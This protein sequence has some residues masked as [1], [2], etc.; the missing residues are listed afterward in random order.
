MTRT[1]LSLLVLTLSAVSAVSATSSADTKTY[2]AAFC[3][4]SN[5]VESDFSRS[6]YRI[7]KTAGS[8]TGTLLCPI[9]HDVFGCSGFGGCVVGI[10]VDIQVL[11]N[12]NTGDVVCTLSARKATGGSF[13]YSTDRTHNRPGVN[14]T[15]EVGGGGAWGTSDNYVLKCS[16]PK[17]DSN[18]YARY[19]YSVDEFD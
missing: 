8:S 12:H 2:H 15:L 4:S 7:T 10:S 9:V 3:Q 14:Q 11:D 17:N 16:M 18:G 6:E 1:K 5:G 19:G 13:W